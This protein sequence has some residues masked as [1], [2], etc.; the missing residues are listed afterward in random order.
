MQIVR[1]Q[2]L[3]RFC[4]EKI[5]KLKVKEKA[6]RDKLEALIEKHKQTIWYRWFGF[7]YN[8]HGYWDHWYTGSAISDF[9]KLLAKAEYNK[10]M[11]WSFT[12][13]DGE[14][15]FVWAKANNVPF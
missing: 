4:N 9:E 7:E 8:D 5:E 15:F 6:S 14:S 10:K 1:T 12:E 11:D 13:Y 3:I 2:D